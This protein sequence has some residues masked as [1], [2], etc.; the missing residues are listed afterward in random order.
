MIQ[1]YTKA[2]LGLVSAILLG[3]LLQVVLM[4]GTSYLI[5]GLRA[6]IPEGGR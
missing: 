1:T 4:G 5:L 2:L 3:L 6:M